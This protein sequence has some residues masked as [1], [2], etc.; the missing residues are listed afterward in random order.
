MS[1]RLDK[2]RI[3]VDFIEDFIMELCVVDLFVKYIWYLMIKDN[4]FD[5]LNF[6]MVGEMLE[7]FIM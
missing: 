6:L 1:L 3:K 2:F 7:F 4:F 5:I